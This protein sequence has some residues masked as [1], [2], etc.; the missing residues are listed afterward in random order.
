[1]SLQRKAIRIG[2]R[3]VLLGLTIAEDRVLPY[4]MVN[5][6][7]DNVE[8]G[9]GSQ[10]LPAI[11]IYTPEE[12]V[13]IQTDTPRTYWRTLTV[14]VEAIVRRAT[15]T[16]APVA[17]QLD[18]ICEQIECLLL[19]QL[20]LPDCPVE[21]HPGKSKLTGIDLETSEE[22]R[23]PLGA[24][25]FEFEIVYQTVVSEE[26]FANVGR[27]AKLGVTYDFP[28]PDAVSEARDDIDLPGA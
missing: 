5:L 26:D 28:P 19:P 18:D 24:A 10:P 4:R 17:N 25:S 27:F 11:Q 14:K 22:T 15:A 16:E 8:L 21:I 13:V 3:D 9:I 12:V 20:V 7:M 2:F 23:V 6:A 1:M